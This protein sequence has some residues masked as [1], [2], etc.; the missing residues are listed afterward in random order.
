[1]LWF[2]WKFQNSCVR[3]LILTSSVKKENCMECD[4]DLISIVEEL[5]SMPTFP[6][7]LSRKILPRCSTFTVPTL[8][9]HKPMVPVR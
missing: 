5:S 7:M 4:Q 9:K 8:Q 2:K 3:N 1:M 6:V